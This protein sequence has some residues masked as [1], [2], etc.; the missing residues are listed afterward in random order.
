[1]SKN[2]IFIILVGHLV[3]RGAYRVQKKRR[4]KVTKNLAEKPEAFCRPMARDDYPSR[5]D[6]AEG[7][8]EPPLRPDFSG[9]P[10]K[11][12][13]FAELTKR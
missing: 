13:L 7:G 3:R 1:M 8:T 9:W 11:K 10:R 4:P 2:F 12:A 6:A 5:N